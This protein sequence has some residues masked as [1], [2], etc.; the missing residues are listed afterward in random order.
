M[1]LSANHLANGTHFTVPIEGL[2]ISRAFTVGAVEYLPSI[3]DIRI[4]DPALGENLMESRIAR[5][6]SQYRAVATARADSI[7]SALDKV[8]QSL[9]VLRVFQFGLMRVSTYTHFGLPGEIAATPIAYMRS[10][11]NGHGFGITTRGHFAGFTLTTAGIDSWEHAAEG[12]HLAATAIAN[13][14]ASESASRALAGVR[15]FSK[16]V[17]TTD[18][19]LRAFLVVAGLGIELTEVVDTLGS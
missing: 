2:E 12:L 15:Y 11:E 6:E 3:D 17:L 4:G 14:G 16:A 10:D 1:T 9:D 18:A 7:E 13:A 19:D 8:S 5:L